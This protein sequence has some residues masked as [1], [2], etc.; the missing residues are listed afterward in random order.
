VLAGL[1]LTAVVP[2]L[3][4][5]RGRLTEALFAALAGS[6][7]RLSALP[8][9]EDD[10]LWG[11]DSALALYVLYELHYRGFAGVDDRWEWDPSLLQ[12]RA[13]LEAGFEDRIGEEV[14]SQ[15][16]VVDVAAELVALAGADGA[17]SLSMRCLE[18]GTLEQMR[19]LAI[20]RSAYQL[21]EADPHTWA[22]PRLR[23]ATKAAL[24]D[25][26][27]DEYGG[28]DVTRMHSE[29]FAAA[30][31][32]L[33]LDDAYG[34]YLDRIPGTTLATVNLVSLFGLHRRWRGALVGH[35]AYFEMCSVT[36]MRN[37]AA[38]LQRLGVP[39][40]GLDFY[41]EHVR[42]DATH[43]VVALDRLAG[44][45]VDDEPDRASEVV[46]GA[47]A[48]KLV[49]QAFASQVLDA[50]TAGRSSLLSGV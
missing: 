43:E 32:A 20:H 25:I 3:P 21:K 30:M 28:G 27:T 9:P 23:G 16:A 29:L 2:R 49:E 45:F 24:I 41:L 19:E 39:G 40:E 37:Y 4:V 47:R 44:G 14:G 13:R 42:A 12:V 26:Q 22:I 50:W 7:G 36:P 35:L 38:T 6:P 17:P 31:R 1:P 10:P 48:L 11:D 15:S 34:A 8:P 18:E 5:A 33:G 46:F